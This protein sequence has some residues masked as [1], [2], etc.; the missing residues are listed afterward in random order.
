MSTITSGAPRLTYSL[1][2]PKENNIYQNYN[3][4]S[5]T[6]LSNSFQ[7][8][9]IYSTDI[10][11]S[12]NYQ[13]NPV[14]SQSQPLIYN[15]D[16][17]NTSN[18]INRF[19]RLHSRLDEINSK[20]C[21]EKIERENLIHSKINTTEMLLDTN[22]QNSLRKL[23]EMKTAI[24]GLSVLF[25]QIR[26]LSKSR[27]IKSNDVLQNFENKFNSRLKEEANRRRNIEKKFSN[28]IDKKFK[29]LKSKIY[30]EAKD[31][32]NTFENLQRFNGKL[33]EL[34][35]NLKKC[36]SLREQ[37]DEEITK[38]VQNKMGYYKELMRKEIKERETFDEENMENIKY[39]L[40]GYNKD[41]RLNK[42]NREQ[43]HGKLIDLV[44][45]T[46]EQLENK[47]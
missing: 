30:E 10:K 46:I 31:R 3:P 37:K 14:I 36:K 33:P 26:Q 40:N 45:A 6:Q 11:T 21:Q 43:N 19:N 35:E 17:S 24:S 15:T 41:F 2:I 9:N 8:N 13:N 16:I 25:E 23:R 22:N 29:D 28:I 20:I 7:N 12:T 34:N 38:I 39:S 4:Q 32:N 1:S 42:L 47:K 5:Q 18:D 27:Q 44:E